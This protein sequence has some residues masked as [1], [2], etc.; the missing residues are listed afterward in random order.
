M[1]LYYQLLWFW[2]KINNSD[3]GVRLLGVILGTASLVFVYKTAE[4]I[5]GKYVARLSIFLLSINFFFVFNLQN[6]R[7][8]PLLLLLTAWSFWEMYKVMNEKAVSIWVYAL[9]VTA[10][11]YTH[12]YAGLIF[13]SQ[14]AIAVY[15]KKFSKFVLSALIVVVLCL[16]LVISPSFR[17]G[18][19]SWV[20]RPSPF[21]LGGTAILLSGDTLV[22][23]ILVWGVVLYGVWKLRN[24]LFH[25]WMVTFLLT[26]IALP[27]SFS[28]IFSIFVRPIYQSVYFISLLIPVSLFLAYGLWSVHSKWV[29]G[30]LLGG[31]V[32]VSALRIGG[33]YT[34]NESLQMVIDNKKEEWREAEKFVSESVGQNDVVIFYAYYGKV[35]F[36]HYVPHE[37]PINMVEI[38]EGTY[39]IAGGKPLPDINYDLV[40]TFKYKY[41]KVW[42]I[43]S[44]VTDIEEQADEIVSLE[45]ALS[46]NYT[47]I[48]TTNFKKIKVV[49][50]A[51]NPLALLGKNGFKFE[52]R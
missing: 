8:Y 27:I 47:K 19:L 29:R 40:N 12:F 32:V 42:L 36:T 15:F 23:A 51:V 37:K 30:L 31:F 5:F 2:G 25:N 4:K 48:R 6:A 35:A 28:Y 11:M 22:G 52:L 49:E 38:A 50:Y 43:E 3:A 39:D 41:S 45:A 13:A 16:P 1:W 46:E 17:S 14:L 24:K 7:S 20:N 26:W 34:K 33:W 18:Q 10:S 44:H 9:V 21:S